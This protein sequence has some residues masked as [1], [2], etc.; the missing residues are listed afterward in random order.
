MAR[1]AKRKQRPRLCIG[2]E[3]TTKRLRQ[4]KKRSKNNAVMEFTVP[5]ARGLSTVRLTFLSKF[6]SQRSLAIQPAALTKS[7]PEVIKVISSKSGGA[8]GANQRAHPAGIRSISLPLGLFQRTNATHSF[9]WKRIRIFFT[10]FC[11]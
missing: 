7:P 4:K 3:L 9:K 1:I 10:Y 11:I 6:L 2:S 5:L 8:E